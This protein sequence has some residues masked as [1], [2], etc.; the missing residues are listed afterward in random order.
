MCLLLPA[1]EYLGHKISAY[2][3]QP[4]DFKVQA[5]KNAPAPMDV[6]QLK[7]FL[8]LVNYYCKFLPNLSNTLAPLC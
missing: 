7:S 1:V 3:L 4:T 5:I 6:S 8:G 2:G